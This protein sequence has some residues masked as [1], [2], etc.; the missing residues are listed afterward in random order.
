MAKLP[1]YTFHLASIAKNIVEHIFNKQGAETVP[2]DLMQLITT[3]G[4]VWTQGRFGG[5]VGHASHMGPI[6]IKALTCL[7]LL[8]WQLLLYCMN[9]LNAVP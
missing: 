1:N 4:A 7:L 9:I 3:D 5:G 8:V 2:C 6:I